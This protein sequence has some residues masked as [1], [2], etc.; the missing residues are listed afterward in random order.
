MKLALENNK[1]RGK[2]MRDVAKY[3]KSKL[4][5]EEKTYFSDV[6]RILKDKPLTDEAGKK[7]E[8]DVNSDPNRT[9]GT[10]TYTSTHS[11]P[12]V[13][14]PGYTNSTDSASGGSYPTYIG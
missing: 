2:I 6:N 5:D 8:E 7:V 10:G 3:V 12:N 13:M 9:V 11:D 14:T 4:T 1:M